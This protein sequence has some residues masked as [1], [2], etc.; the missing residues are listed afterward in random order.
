MC[1]FG[2]VQLVLLLVKQKLLMPVTCDEGQL[3]FVLPAGSRHSKP[4]VM[5]MTFT[6]QAV[7]KFASNGRK[8][9]KT[10]SPSRQCVVGLSN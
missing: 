7:D 2:Q 4:R 10:K 6:G 3:L 1:L 8:K 5:Q 9:K